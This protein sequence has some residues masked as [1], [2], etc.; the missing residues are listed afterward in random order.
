MALRET[1]IHWIRP[2]V[3]L[4]RNIASLIGAVITTS[5][6]I[7]LVSFW[8]F[9]IITDARIPPYFGVIF[10]LILPALFVFG[11]ILIPLGALWR[12]HSLLIRKALP[13][14]YPQIDFHDPM[15]R[16]TGY[17]VA[18]LTV[19]N[20]VIV[21]S[22]SYRGVEYM[23][24]VSFCGQTCHT[25][26]Q[27]EHT[28]Y[29]NSPHSRVECVSCH[30][31]PGASWF[32]R[33]KLSGVRQ[34]FA[35]MLHTY[36]TPIPTPVEN[37][38]PAQETCEQCHWPQMFQGDKLLI[39]TSF[40]DDEKNTPATTVLL[41]KI[42]GR[43][44]ERSVGIHGRHLSDPA[45][46]N[47]VRY[48]ATDRARQ[49]IPRISYTE[50][51]G[52]V[53]EFNAGD[54]KA[55]PEELAR[56]PRIMDCVDCHNR[57]THT[58]LPAADAVDRAMSESHIDPILPFIKKKAVEVLQMSYPDSQSAERQ[59]SSALDDF[60]RAKYPDIYQKEKRA[61]ATSVEEVKNIYLRN[62]F[63]EMKVTWGTYANNIG[64][65]NSPG[66][67]RCHDGNHAGKDGR[68]I[69]QDC[70]ACHALLAVQEQNPQILSQ[71]QI[72]NGGSR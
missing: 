30:I 12:R 62:V 58:F 63:P 45:T 67:F 38:R 31:G 10:Y 22:A 1:L 48:W 8:A 6:G 47:R 69:T 42:G 49:V 70:S 25:V 36:E 19:L 59:I 28:A 3:F 29:R 54:T 2:L 35:V 55:S 37:L 53:V 17:W 14:V 16:R 13:A 21:G 7:T 60:Y 56:P 50:D 46:A 18:C 32:V 65:M 52:T 15:L 11:L 61:L 27:P 71:L 24:S 41:M 43:T 57:P 23:G 26:M 44:W 40:G 66:C 72:H 5:M 68:Q 4:G 20:V 51:D 39:R 64:H 9:Q 34:V 33:S